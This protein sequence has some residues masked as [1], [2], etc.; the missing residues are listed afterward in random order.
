MHGVTTDSKPAWDVL[1]AAAAEAGIEIEGAQLIRD[2]SNVMYRLSGGIVARI[3]RP[4]TA[5]TARRE[6]ETAT[7]LASH[8]IPAVKVV[9]DLPQLVVAA[10]RPVTWWHLLP[11]HRPATP[12]ELATVLKAVHSLNVPTRPELPLHNPFTDIAP[13]IRAATSINADDRDWLLQRLDQLQADYRQLETTQDRYVLHGDAWQGN[14]AVPDDGR[15]ILLDLEA[16]AIGPKQWDLV[17]IAVDYTDFAR[18]TDADYKA[19]LTAYGDNDITE[20]PEFRTFADIQELRWVAFA[21]SKAASNPDAAREAQH[22]I[23][24]LQGE[25]SRPWTWSA[26]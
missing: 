26:L 2:G 24:C 12:G 10:E 16:F 7:W 19:F 25:E 5:D 3:G 22:R 18:L 4:G 20:T 23:A 11:P 1:G 15:P 13:R 8:G 9:E 14:V 21:A 6:V 17:Q